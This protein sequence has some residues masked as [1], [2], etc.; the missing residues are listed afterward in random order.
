MAQPT[1]SADSILRD[2]FGY[3]SF[4]PGQREVIDAVLAGRDC[5]AVMPTGAGKSLTFQVPA[6][7]LSKT[8]LVLSPLISLMKDQVDALNVLGF[9]ATAINSSLEHDEWRRQVRGL[10]RGEYELAYIAPEALDGRLRDRLRACPVS[11]VVVDEAHCISQWGHDF[12]PAYRRLQGLRSE[13]GDVPVLALT[14]TATRRVARDIIRQLGMRKPAGYKGSFFRSNLQISCRKKGEGDTRRELLALIRRHPGESGIVYCLARK[15]VEQTVAFLRREGIRAAPYHAGLDA[16][17]RVAHQD[18]FA[19]DEVDVIVATIAFGMGID[20]PNVRFVI[21]RD[22]PGDIESWYQEMGRAG[23]DG[24]P[25]E[26]VL[27]YSWADVKLRE[28]F[29]DEV[30][31]GELRREKRGATTRLYRLVESEECR[32]KGILTHFDERIAPCGTSC[33]RCSGVTVQDLVAESRGRRAV[34]SPLDFPSGDMRERGRRVGSRTNVGVAEEKRSPSDP[35]FQKLRALRKRLADAQGVP[36]YVVFGDQVLWNMIDR[37]PANRTEL[38]Q[39]SGVGPVKAERYGDA[40]L[41]VLHEG[42][43]SE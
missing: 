15:T 20:K 19:R 39:V 38:L 32:H 23:R 37:R 12:R 6:R 40:F 24:L 30:E 7:L 3:E 27:F 11:L 13:L 26:C 35:V 16:A 28:R 42:D 25:S 22:M 43:D 9:R 4:R 18:A 29:L 1:L 31:D 17:E 8:V 2:V 41:Q 34:V 14:A 10:E 33:D 21:H 36:A 5:I